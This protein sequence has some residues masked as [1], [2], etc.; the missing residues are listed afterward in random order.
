MEILQK[1]EEM[2]LGRQRENWIDDT[3]LEFPRTGFWIIHVIGTVMIF[4]LGM[5]FAFHKA[6][7]PMIAYRLLRRLMHS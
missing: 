4:I 3:A 7:V 5:K 2:N 6:P 1:K